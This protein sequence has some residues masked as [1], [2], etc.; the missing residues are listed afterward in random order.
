MLQGVTPSIS[1]GV[2]CATALDRNLRLA[3]QLQVEGTPTLVYADG[4][5][6]AGYAEADVVQRRMVAA[7]AGVL[8]PGVKTATKRPEQP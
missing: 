5:R 4:T 1:R 7:A 6:S 8:Q 3:R 2:E